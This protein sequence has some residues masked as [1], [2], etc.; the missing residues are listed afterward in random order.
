MIMDASITT[1][2]SPLSWET[3]LETAIDLVDGLLD[4]YYEYITHS[5]A[6]RLQEHDLDTVA[7]L[8]GETKTLDTLR[9]TLQSTQEALLNWVHA[10]HDDYQSAEDPLQQHD[11]LRREWHDRIKPHLQTPMR[12]FLC[13]ILDTLSHHAPMKRGELLRAT[14]P[15]VRPML[16]HRDL[17]ILQNPQ[18]VH[19]HNTVTHTLVRAEEHQLVTKVV[20]GYWEITP[21]GE[22]YLT[23]RCSG[24][25][26][27]GQNTLMVGTATGRR[28]DLHAT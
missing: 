21:Q 2:D 9:I 4:D 19:W 23:S 17:E 14:E 1:N 8:F 27:T 5:I 24:P 12:A 3:E 26:N 15:L 6:V 25:G 11:Q 22:A 28:R 18:V 20:P 13:P 16:N 10:H 7:E